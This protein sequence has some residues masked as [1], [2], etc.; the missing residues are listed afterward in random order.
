L[1]ELVEDITHHIALGN[2]NEDDQTPP[3]ERKKRLY[4]PMVKA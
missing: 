2:D 1:N 3:L 4:L